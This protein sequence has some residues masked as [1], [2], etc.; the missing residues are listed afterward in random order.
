MPCTLLDW[1][2]TTHLH[3]SQYRSLFEVGRCWMELRER[4]IIAGLMLC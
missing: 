4:C 2:Q 3:F 1:H